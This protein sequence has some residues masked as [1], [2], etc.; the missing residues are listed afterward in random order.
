MESTIGDLQWRRRQHERQQRE[1]VAQ[2][3]A[4]AVL[5]KVVHERPVVFLADLIEQPVAFPDRSADG[6]FAS[7]NFEDALRIDADERILRHDAREGAAAL[8]AHF[9]AEILEPQEQPIGGA[10][11]DADSEHA[12]QPAPHCK[13]LVCVDQDV[14]E[15]A[16]MLFHHT[17]QRAR[18]LLRDRV[19]RQQ[20]DHVWHECS[21]NAVLVTQHGQDPIAIA[22]AQCEDLLNLGILDC[23]AGHCVRR[24]AERGGRAEKVCDVAIVRRIV[25]RVVMSSTS[26][27]SSS[28][29]RLIRL[30]SSV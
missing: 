20:G 23:Q 29:A 15:L 14:G 2:A 17:P 26:P 8:E 22:R 11:R 6:H 13:R 30:R 9:E 12:R 16:D 4:R 27:R 3:L 19:P 1:H 21:R 18:H 25:D 7:D 24:L 28:T 5:Q 10:L